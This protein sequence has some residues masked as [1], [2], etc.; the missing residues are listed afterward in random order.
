M[1][2]NGGIGGSRTVESTRNRL[3]GGE[4]AAFPIQIF[5]YRRIAT[6]SETLVGSSSS[7]KS[8]LSNEQEAQSSDEQCACSVFPEATVF[9]RVIVSSDFG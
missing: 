2:N 1:R 7:P 5:P 8:E 4:T 9:S 6:S 3:G